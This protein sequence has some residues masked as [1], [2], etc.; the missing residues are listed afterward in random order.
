MTID[1]IKLKLL[2]ILAINCIPKDPK[3]DCIKKELKEN[4]SIMSNNTISTN[5]L[6]NMYIKLR[7]LG[8]NNN[9]ALPSEIEDLL[10]FIKDQLS[11]KKKTTILKENI[12]KTFNGLPFN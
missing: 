4:Y 8:T 2:T 1:V 10:V 9:L 5:Q 3:F 7:T 12:K 6:K 11:K